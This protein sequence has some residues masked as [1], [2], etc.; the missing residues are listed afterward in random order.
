MGND[1]L[2]RIASRLDSREPLVNAKRLAGVAV[3]V[4]ADA[5]ASTLLIKRA[6]RPGD[7]WSGQVAFPGGKKTESDVSLRDTAVRETLEE[8]GVDLVRASR[9]LGYFRPFRTHTGKM[10]VVPSVYQIDGSVQ[11]VPNAEVS[12]F[13]WIPW[14]S[15][16]NPASSGTYRLAGVGTLAD[17]PSFNI[18]G[19]VIW[20]L[21]H[22]IISSLLTG[23]GASPRNR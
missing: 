6:E 18:E 7:P 2:S 17:L 4:T 8:V 13:R 11:V 19:F 22:R 15:F 21:T 3:L 20:G 23:E 12:S 5:E 10:D 1:I 9:F 16:L 14:E